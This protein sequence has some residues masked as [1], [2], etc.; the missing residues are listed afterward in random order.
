MPPPQTHLDKHGFPIPASFGPRGPEGAPARPTRAKAPRKQR[1]WLR[2]MLLAYL[3][4]LLGALAH[5]LGLV[6]GVRELLA[7]RCLHDGWLAMRNDD[8]AE[9]EQ[10]FSRAVWLAPNRFEPLFSRAVARRQQ[11][12]FD[13]CLA[14][15]NQVLVIQPRNTEALLFRAD[16]LQ[17]RQQHAAAL[18]DVSRAVEI[19]GGTQPGPLNNRA[20]LRARAGVELEA[21]LADI[22]QALEMVGGDNAAYLDTRGYVHFMLGRHPEALADLNA[23][24]ELEQ[25]LGFSPEHDENLAVMY[26]HRGQVYSALGDESRAQEDTQLALQLGYSVARGVW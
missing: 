18:A 8:F 6:S 7:Q 16:L 15:V 11:L 17:Q 10:Q 23:A 19:T 4:L 14:D 26:F 22:E 25:Q 24:I 9:A 3:L 2:L 1:P 13:G 20:Y 21:A 5:H 12:D